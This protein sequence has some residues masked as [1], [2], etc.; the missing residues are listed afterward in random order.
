MAIYLLPII[1]YRLMKNNKDWLALGL[2]LFICL[3]FNSATFSVGLI[4]IA[5]VIGLRKFTHFQNKKKF[6]V[7]VLALSVIAVLLILSGYIN[8]S[9]LTDRISAILLT[10]YQADPAGITN[11]SAI[12]WLNGWSQAYDTLLVTRGL[13]L[14]FNQMGCGDFVNIG[15]FSDHISL[16]T[17]G[18]VLN[19]NDGSFLISKLASELGVVGLSIASYLCYQSYLAIS[20]YVNVS[21]DANTSE[22]PLLAI[23]AIGGICVLQLL[24]I[25]S[26]SYFLE[27]VILDLSLLL[28]ASHAKK[29]KV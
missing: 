6:L 28:L 22:A 10:I 23:N 18:V 26:N 3:Y 24:F 17:G 16:W 27:P 19:W 12:V 1:G 11:A 8:I 13:G 9:I 4:L 20:R 25:R 29:G 7:Y 2:T 14:G 15:R 5:L 21:H